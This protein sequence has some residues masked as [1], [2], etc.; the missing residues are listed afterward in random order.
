MYVS[1]YMFTPCVIYLCMQYEY[2]SLERPEDGVRTPR[3]MGS[4]ELPERNAGN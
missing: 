2:R 1:L 3:V 4:L